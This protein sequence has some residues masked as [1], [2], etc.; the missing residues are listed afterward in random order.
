[1]TAQKK[2]GALIGCGFFAHNH[3]NAWAQLADI[4]IVAVCDIDKHRAEQLAERFGVSNVYTDADWLLNGMKLDFVDIATT[5]PSHR[6]LVEL[7]A[8]KGVAAICQKP[9]AETMAAATSMVAVC[10]TAG[11]PLIVHENFRWQR[12]FVVMRDL[13]ALGRI[14]APHFARFSFRHGYDN[15]RNQPYLAQIERFTIMDIGLHLFDLARFFVGEVTQLSCNAQHLNPHVRGED[16]FTA[17]LQHANGA[18]SI[19]DCSFQSVRQPE[20]FPQTFAEIEGPDGTLILGQDYTLVLHDAKGRHDIPCAPAVPD[21]GS[22]PWH[23]VQDSVIRFQSHVADVLHGRAPPQPSGADN[24][25][26]LAL[27]LA[28]YDAVALKQTINMAKWQEGTS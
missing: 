15:Y 16:A 28:A 21:W 7:A 24:L 14:G 9:F 19:C 2:R 17:L 18:T 8:A 10:A 11:V 23:A 5:A 12:P 25:L 1:M 27:S 13:I 6:Q 4:E 20:P 26:T 22:D 3:M